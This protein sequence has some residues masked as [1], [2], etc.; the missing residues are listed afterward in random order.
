MFREA[1]EGDEHT[2]MECVCT[3]WGWGIRSVEYMCMCV[4]GGSL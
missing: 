1:K 3:C 4:E 2:N